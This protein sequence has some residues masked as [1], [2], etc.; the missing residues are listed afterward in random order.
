MEAGTVV[1]KGISWGLLQQGCHL[2]K[3]HC[4][5]RD[6][7]GWGAP[8]GPRPQWSLPLQEILCHQQ[9]VGWDSSWKSLKMD[10]RPSG[11]I[12]HLGLGQRLVSLGGHFLG[13]RGCPHQDSPESTVCP[14]EW[15][16]WQ[17][18]VGVPQAFSRL[19]LPLKM[20]WSSWAGVIQE[21]LGLREHPSE[22]PG[23]P[24]RR[25]WPL[26]CSQ[27]LLPEPSTC[28]GVG[29]LL[30]AGIDVVEAPA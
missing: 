8:F 2:M 23:L 14:H 22:P 24:R 30:G 13:L 18:H 5:A 3:P 10:M 17:G 20:A 15:V 26:P 21:S 7:E 27:P 4:P 16:R 1:P 25:D 11:H 28:V 6:T 29:G 9:V 12:L 19:P